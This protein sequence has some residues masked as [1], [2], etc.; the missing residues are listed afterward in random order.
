MFI[1]LI[2]V[3]TEYSWYDTKTQD[4]KTKK[5]SH[6]AKFFKIEDVEKIIEYDD[7]DSNKYLVIVKDKNPL[8]TFSKYAIQFTCKNIIYWKEGKII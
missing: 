1:K 2:N 3:T 8:N 7:D 5:E 6:I 4:V